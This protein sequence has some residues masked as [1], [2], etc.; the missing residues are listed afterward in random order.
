MD[1]CTSGGCQL[2][3]DVSLKECGIV[4]G[5][6]VFLHLV[7]PDKSVFRYV[8]FLVF[9]GKEAKQSQIK[10]TCTNQMHVAYGSDVVIGNTVATEMLKLLV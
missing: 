8:C 5:F 9:C 3:S 2:N 4:T 10:D 7:E 6:R 1:C